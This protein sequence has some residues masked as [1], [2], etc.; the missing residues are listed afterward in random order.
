MKRQATA[1]RN[2]GDHRGFYEEVNRSPQ[3]TSPTVDEILLDIQ[4]SKQRLSRSSSLESS[5]TGRPQ[6]PSITA[7]QA[8]ATAAI[9]GAEALAMLSASSG[10]LGNIQGLRGLAEQATAALRRGSDSRSA[11]GQQAST[12]L[13]PPGGGASM[14]FNTSSATM[15]GLA[16]DV[17]AQVAASPEGDCE[18]AHGEQGPA[19]LDPLM[20]EACWELM[21]ESNG[22]PEPGSPETGDT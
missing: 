18:Q 15:R 1:V 22:S 19:G 2:E 4:R 17:A 14:G 11:A 3:R 20:A 16:V 6:F 7:A 21:H 9:P 13:A 5:P 12:S 10:P 8:L